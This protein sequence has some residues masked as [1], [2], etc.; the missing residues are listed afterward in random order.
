MAALRPGVWCSA[1]MKSLFLTLHTSEGGGGHEAR[2]EKWGQVLGGMGKPT[3][4][5]P[6]L[7]DQPFLKRVPWV[8]PR[9]FQGGP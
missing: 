2:M 3:I 4:Y 8:S 9:P 6:Y 7:Q 1:L 5:T